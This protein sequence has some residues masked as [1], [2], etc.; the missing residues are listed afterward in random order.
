M[1]GVGLGVGVA[2]GGNGDGPETIGGS[3]AG[4]YQVGALGDG[5]LCGSEGGGATGIAQ[6]ADGQETARR[7]GRE[8]MTGA[9]SERQLRDIEGANVGRGDAATIREADTYRSGS[10]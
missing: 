9:G 2:D 8:N 10:D 6:E 3:Q 1:H 7:E 4:E 5:A